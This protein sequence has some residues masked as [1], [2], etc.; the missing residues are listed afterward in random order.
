[1]TG[2]DV[3]KGQIPYE[4]LLRDTKLVE[5]TLLGISWNNIVSFW[6]ENDLA[7]E[8]NRNSGQRLLKKVFVIVA[9]FLSKNMCVIAQNRGSEQLFFI[10]VE[11][12]A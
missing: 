10:T 1:M 7:Q 9:T 5:R 12:A 4:R 6:D 3:I 11:S 2:E 8:T